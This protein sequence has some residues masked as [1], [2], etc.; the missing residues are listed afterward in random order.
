[1]WIFFL[2]RF[3]PCLGLGGLIGFLFVFFFVPIASIAW[4]I[5]FADIQSADVDFKNAKRNKNIALLI[6]APAVI[7][8]LLWVTMLVLAVLGRV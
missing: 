6:W 3:I 1:M 5:K 8:M 7:L 4:Q 2:I